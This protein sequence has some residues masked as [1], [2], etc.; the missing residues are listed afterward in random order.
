MFSKFECTCR[1]SILEF[2]KNRIAV[3]SKKSGTKNFILLLKP[4]TL[5]PIVTST[6]PRASI[7]INV[8]LH[9]PKQL[10]S[11]FIH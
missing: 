5:N 7:K 8:V 1:W 9:D 10:L 11:R 4:F 6:N 3:K 2:H